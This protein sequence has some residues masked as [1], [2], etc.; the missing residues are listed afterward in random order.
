M[1]CIDVCS[2]G[3]D[4]LAYPLLH[5]IGGRSGECDQCQII[6]L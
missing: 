2:F 6:G 1:E 5:F 4:A 3:F